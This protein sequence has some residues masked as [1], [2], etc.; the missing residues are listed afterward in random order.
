MNNYRKVL[1][2][3]FFKYIA[4]LPL[5]LREIMLNPG[6][7]GAACPSSHRLAKSVAAQ[8]PIAS[9]PIVELGAGTGVI[10]AALLARE[11]LPK[12]FLIIERAPALVQ[13]LKN[14]FPTLNIIQGDARE[15][16]H[17]LP[18]AQLPVNTIVSSLPLRTLPQTV[19]KTIGKQ[20]ENVLKT[21]GLFIQFTYS[22]YTKPMPPSPRLQWIYSKYIWW[23]LPPARID[24]FRYVR[25]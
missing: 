2:R 22:F 11:V 9:G 12:E 15:L 21:D 17:L 14:R 19:V 25:S 16:E 20:V 10:T 3:P 6:A 8:V 13:H 24:V 5:F 7:M 1:H 23:N 18:S 4:D